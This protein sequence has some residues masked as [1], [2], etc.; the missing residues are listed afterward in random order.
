MVVV[1][2]RTSFFTN[3]SIIIF[4]V[5]TCGCFCYKAFI[6]SDILLLGTLLNMLADK[7]LKKVQISLSK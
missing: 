2:L 3:I 4:F 5:V 6:D 7:N 1:F